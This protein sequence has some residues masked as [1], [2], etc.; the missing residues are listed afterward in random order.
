MSGPDEEWTRSLALKRPENNS[1]REK[2]REENRISINKIVSVTIL[3]NRIVFFLFLL[4]STPE[5]ER[6][7]LKQDEIC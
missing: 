7:R 2:T 3:A 5:Y 4:S 6:E 1:K